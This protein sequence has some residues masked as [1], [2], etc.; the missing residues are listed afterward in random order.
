MVLS[1]AHYFEVLHVARLFS[2]PRALNV[3]PH[4][5]LQRAGFRFVLSHETRPGPINA[6]QITTRWVLERPGSSA[7]GP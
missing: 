4:R 3:A 7:P 5:T 6:L 2:E 1:A